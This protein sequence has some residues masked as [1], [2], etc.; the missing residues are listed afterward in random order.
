MKQH[1]EE[2]MRV[3][4]LGDV[5]VHTGLEAELAVGRHRIGGHGDDG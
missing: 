3:D 4:R 2:L 5:V 1:A